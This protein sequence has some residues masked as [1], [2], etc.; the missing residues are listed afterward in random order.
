[1]GW[2]FIAC[3]RLDEGHGCETCEVEKGFCGVS[4]LD[5]IDMADASDDR[6]EWAGFEVD[7][8]SGRMTV[9]QFLGCCMIGLNEQGNST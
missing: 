2:F 6:K 1:M 7:G 3:R 4:T 8:D 5:E 9:S